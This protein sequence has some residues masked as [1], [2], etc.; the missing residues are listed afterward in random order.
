MRVTGAR[1]F[2]TATLL[3][4]TTGAWSATGLNLDRL[5]EL[6]GHG[7]TAPQ[8]AVLGLHLYRDEM[9]HPTPRPK[10]P[11]TDYHTHD[12]VLAEI[13]RKLAAVSAD[14]PTLKHEWSSMH[15]GEVKDSLTIFLALKGQPEVKDDVAHYLTERKNPL[16][17]RELA[18]TAVGALA[19][20]TQDAKLGDAL[21]QAIREDT[22]G[23]YK[24]NKGGGMTV[25][26]P[27]RRAAAAAVR[28][29]D[30]GG[31]LLPSYVTAAADHAQAEVKLPAPKKKEGGGAPPKK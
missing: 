29:M 6:D 16:R 24:P 11:F 28:K 3:I 4:A 18:A 21:A 1:F 20:K 19:I 14:I 25:I 22:Q 15:A 31:L 27:V 7:L 17:L 13:T 2:A 23:Q 9:V 8:K 10:P 12:Y 30:K 5:K 26:F